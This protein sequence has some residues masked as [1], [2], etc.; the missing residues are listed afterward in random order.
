MIELLKRSFDYKRI[1]LEVKIVLPIPF[2]RSLLSACGR[3]T[4]SLLRDPLKGLQNDNQA[5]R[6]EISPNV[7]DVHHCLL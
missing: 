2:R 5:A 7:F 4:G 3:R 6:H 1:T